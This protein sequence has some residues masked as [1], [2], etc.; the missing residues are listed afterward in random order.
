MNCN[1]CLHTIQRCLLLHRR[2]RC[3]LCQHFILDTIPS[4]NYQ[5]HQQHKATEF[6]KCKH[7]FLYIKYYYF[8]QL[9]MVLSFR[10]QKLC[11]HGFENWGFSF[12][13]RIL[14]LLLFLLS[15]ISLLHLLINVFRFVFALQ[16][17]YFS[18]INYPHDLHPFQ[19]KDKI[20]INEILKHYQK[21]NKY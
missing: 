3:C 13:C 7:I 8:T 2:C 10:V 9:K 14:L 12:L 11:L 19:T 6:F 20:K 4:G 1:F 18:L 17:V 5:T 21:I 15:C 16:S